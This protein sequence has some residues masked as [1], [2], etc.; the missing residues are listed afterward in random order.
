MIYIIATHSVY[1]NNTEAFGP[2][3]SIAAFLA[4]KKQKVLFLKHALEGSKESVAILPDQS[5]EKIELPGNGI[6]SRGIREIKLNLKFSASEK[7]E[8]IFIGVDPI[9]GFAGSLLKILGKTDKF[10]YLT[11]DYIEKRFNNW[12]LNACYHLADRICLL[13]SDEVWSVSSRI[14]NKRKR[15]GVPDRKNKLIV[16]SPDFHSIKRKDY[17]GNQNLVVISPLS[18]ALNL[19]PIINSLKP[20]FSKYLKLKLEIIGSG[21][22]EE[23]FK[24]MVHDQELEEEIHFLGW[25]QHDEILDI[26]CS[27]FL[28][29]ALYTGAASWNVYGDSMKAREYVACGLPVIINEIPSTAEEVKSY[30]AG[31]VLSS[32]SETKITNFVEKCLTDKEYYLSLRENALKM[33]QDFDKTKIL[34]ELL[35]L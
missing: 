23:N 31:L 27:S 33:G 6:L 10:I 24:Q 5:V 16:N 9:N 32:I 19:S 35:H 4:A 14:M 22:E 2:A 25:K 13:F 12:F 17:N 34:S 29:F 21:E 20:L 15:Q 30:H 18:K 8:N 28:G 11:A 1:K 26:M 7:E 3:N